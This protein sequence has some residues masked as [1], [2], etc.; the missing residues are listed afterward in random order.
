M[1]T[2]TDA[3]GR[4]K[5]AVNSWTCALPLVWKGK[6]I[7]EG[8]AQ[9]LTKATGVL[10]TDKTVETVADRIGAVERAFNA[11]QGITTADDMLPQRIQFKNTPEGEK[12]RE[13]HISMVKAWY[14]K[15]GYSTQT[16]LPTRKS[17]E[18]LGMGYAADILDKRLPC[19]KWDGPWLKDL[20]TY[21]RGG[22][23]V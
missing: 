8:L 11:L 10:H 14:K 4:Y 15:K 17:W 18:N 19:K 5:G 21:P 16:G 2:L 13:H 9:M 6:A 20:S 22:K 23:R 3:I 7:F 1:T 12:E